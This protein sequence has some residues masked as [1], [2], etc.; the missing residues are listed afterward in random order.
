M[1]KKRAAWI[2]ENGPCKNCGS[3]LNL[4]VDH[5]DA[6]TKSFSPARI[7]GLRKDRAEDELKKCQVLCHECHLSKTKVDMRLRLKHGT[8]SFYRNGCRCKECTNAH[9]TAVNVWRWKTGKRKNTPKHGN[10]RNKNENTLQRTE[11]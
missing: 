2:Q 3:S 9:T 6:T 4:E 8:D 11:A 5:I 1:K 10:N 7:W